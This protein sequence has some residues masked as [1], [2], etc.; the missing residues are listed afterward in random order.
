VRHFDVLVIGSGVAG[1]SVA[2][3]CADAG[4]SVAV[5]DC[6][7]FGGTCVLRGCHPKKILWS[8]AEVV[9]RA[10]AQSGTGVAGDVRLDWASAVAF[11]RLFTRPATASTEKGLADAGATLLHGTARFV[12]PAQLDVA[13]ET[14]T[15]DH[16]V[17]ATGARPASVGIEGQ[18]LLATSEDFM[19]LD[20]LG[21]RVV[22]IGGGY[23]SFEFAH[24]A[25]ATGAE[26]T[27][28]HRGP[29]P[30]GGF[31]PDLT[32]MLVKAYRDRGIDVRLGWPVASV[33]RE[34]GHLA[35]VGP[36]R[37][38]CDLAVHG[39]GRAPDL[40]D[41]DLDAGNVA[42]ERAGVSVDAYMRSVS[43]PRVYAA[44]D[45]AAPGLP[46]TPVGVRQGA[47]VAANIKQPGSVTFDG[48]I[49]PSAVFSDPPLARVG[50]T[51]QEA[52]DAGLDAEVRMTDTS[53]W[54]STRRVGLKTT[55][56]KIILDRAKGTI[57][58]AH[59]LGHGA[60]EIVNV[61]ALA[62]RQGVT[63]RAI[64][65][66]LWSYPTATSDVKYLL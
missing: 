53:G 33:S 30:L 60:D 55:G 54:E 59:L 58:G 14:V 21:A 37:I 41:L 46:L 66:S 7:P 13:G 56:A 1:Q 9:D 27:I 24:M 8:A 44:G 17:I 4:M 12:S 40:D 25:Q 42:R 62:M 5:A 31:D 57:L 23:I 3:D 16:T 6:R 29:A 49:T 50:M 28:V 61:F 2:Y 63:A 11:K 45:A 36:E 43:N 64:R 32:M 26:V 34:E 48:S 52:L 10:H 47:I 39:A 35:V 65:E 15:A 18:E 19:E 20:A 38:A 51:E 22:F